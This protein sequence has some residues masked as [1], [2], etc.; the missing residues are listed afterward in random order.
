[1][2]KWQINDKKGILGLNCERTVWSFWEWRSTSAVPSGPQSSPGLWQ[3][4]RN[5]CGK[6]EKEPQIQFLSWFKDGWDHCP[7]D[8]GCKEKK[9]QE[10]DHQRQVS[11]YTW[12]GTKSLHLE[13]WGEQW[14]FSGIWPRGIPA[15][16]PQWVPSGASNVEARRRWK[17]WW[18]VTG[19][20][21]RGRQPAYSL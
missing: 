2:Q 7:I 5:T 8:G 1:M 13:C 3:R 6:I 21:V 14:Q 9:R 18:D 17:L 4:K 10:A 12:G 11:L 20:T 15:R 16:C 19:S